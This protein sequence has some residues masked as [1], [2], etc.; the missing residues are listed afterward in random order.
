MKYRIK[1]DDPTNDG[2]L[3]LTPFMLFALL[4][5]FMGVKSKWVIE[6]KK[7]WWNKWK[8]VEEYND[9]TEAYIHYMKLAYNINIEEEIVFPHNKNKNKKQT[10]IL[11]CQYNDKPIDLEYKYTVGY[12]P[13]NYERYYHACYSG[14]SYED[15]L[16]KLW[17]DMEIKKILN[18]NESCMEIEKQRRKLEKIEYKNKIY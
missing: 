10:C 4:F 15:A 7:H 16:G 12:K 5:A 3:W 17:C 13:R 1:Y 14:K 11:T 2:W 6:Q 18:R 8:V 9:Q